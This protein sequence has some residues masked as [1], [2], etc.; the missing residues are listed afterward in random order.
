MGWGKRFPT[1]QLHCTSRGGGTPLSLAR[2]RSFA[3]AAAGRQSLPAA[4]PPLARL[5]FGRRSPVAVHPA[6]CHA[7]P[8]GGAAVAPRVARRIDPYGGSAAGDSAITLSQSRPESRTGTASS[9]PPAHWPRP[10][11]HQTSLRTIQ[12]LWLQHACDWLW[13]V[14]VTVTAAADL[15]QRRPG[16]RCHEIQQMLLASVRIFKLL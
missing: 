2:R 8:S 6:M 5:T 10:V 3:S 9:L 7:S 4:A 16:L 1:R 11:L 15:W 12:P 14:R 13:R